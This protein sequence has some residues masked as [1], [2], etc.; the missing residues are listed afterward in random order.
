[1]TYYV[2]WLVIVRM[3]LHTL[4]D[5]YVC[6]QQCQECRRNHAA[7]LVI[8]R[9]TLNVTNPQAILSSGFALLL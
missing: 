4:C 8:C 7:E 3:M 5:V 9:E 1:M 6:W 2:I